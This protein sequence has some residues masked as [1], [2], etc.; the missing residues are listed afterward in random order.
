MR[1]YIYQ[2][3]A[4]FLLFLPLQGKGL[5]YLCNYNIKNGLPDNSVNCITQDSNGYIW[6]GTSNGLARFDGLLFTVFKH[7]RDDSST[8]AN[9]NIHTFLANKHGLYFSTDLGVDFYNSGDNTFHHCE[10]PGQKGYKRIITMAETSAGMFATDYSGQLYRIEGTTFWN[11]SPK[12]KVY[13]VAAMGAPEKP[14]ISLPRPTTSYCCCRPT[15][16]AYWPLPRP[17][18]RLQP[19]TWFTTASDKAAYTRAMA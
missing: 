3:I 12:F 19:T 14:N 16:N 11:I 17:R 5:P 9:N 18:S 2:A 10:F 1:R 13:A 8:I 4:I 7:N 15:R 6:A